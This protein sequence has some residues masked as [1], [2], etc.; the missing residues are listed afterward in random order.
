MAAQIGLPA[1]G[2]VDRNTV[3]GLVRAH[4]AAQATGVRAV[5]GCRLDL[6]EGTSLLLYPHDKAAWSRLCRLLTIGKRRAGKGACDLGW[7]D[8][9]EH[10]AGFSAVLIDDTPGEEMAMN[11]ARLRQAFGEEAHLA[12]VR[13]FLP[14]DLDRLDRAAGLARAARVQT[15]A[16]NDALY[17]IPSR[18]ILQDVVTAI[19]EGCT[20]DDLGRRRERSAGRWLKPP[21]EMARLFARWPEAVAATEKLTAKCCFS[22]SELT[23]Q[24]PDEISPEGEPAQEWLARL[25]RERLPTRYP[26]GA[27]PK[28]LEQIDHEL[29]L[30]GELRYAPYFLTVY[31]IVEAANAMGILCQGRG[32]AANSAVCFVLGITAIR[33]EE[34]GL[35]FERFVS[36][37]RGEPPDIDVD[38]DSGRREEVIQWVYN[39]YGRDHAALTATIVRYRGRGAIREVGK[40]LGL[41]EDITAALSKMT[42]AWDAKGVTDAQAKE[43]NLNL[44]DRRLRMTL[45]LARLLMGAPRHL[46]QHPGGFVLTAAPLID[47]VPIEPAAMEDR[48]VIEWDKDDIDALHF[49]KVDVLGLGM[50]GAMS[51]FFDMLREYKGESYDLA[52]VPP[53]EEDVYDMICAADTVGVFQIE[54]RAQMAMLPRMRPRN[55]DDLTVEV[56]VVRPGPIQGEM[57]HPYLKRRQGLEVPHYPTPEFREV[58]EK[59]LGVPLFQEQA[60]SIAIKCGGFTPGE[61]D[62]LRR[63]MAT[64]K[65]TG[66]VS[67]FRDKL[68]AGMVDHGLSREFAAR[69]FKQLEGFGS[70]GFPMSHAASFAKIAYIS[71][72]AKCRHPDLFLA[73]LLNA[74]PMGFYAPAQLVW[75][76]R[77]HGVEVRPVDVNHSRWDCTIEE[78]SREKGW[79]AIRLGLRMVSGFGEVDAARL[80]GARMEMPFADPEELQLRAGLTGRAVAQLVDADAFG[81]CTMDRRAAGWHAAKLRD[82][83][84]PL[85]AEEWAAPR[86]RHEAG[87]GF[88]PAPMTQGREVVEDYLTT[89]LSL[90]AH[91]VSFIRPALHRK[92]CRRAADVLTLKDRIHLRVAGLV[93]A[94]QRP[95][96]A[97]GVMFMTLEDETGPMNIIVWP[98]L[99]QKYRRIV[100]TASMIG[101]EGQLQ[102]E[103]DVRHIITHRLVDLSGALARVGEQGPVEWRTGRGDEARHGGGPDA[104][105]IVPARGGA[106][107]TR[108]VGR[109]GEADNVRS[110][111]SP[112]LA[113]QV[114]EHPLKLRPRNFR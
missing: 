7:E 106:Q 8:V 60:M 4:Q 57:V 71:S 88:A 69:T 61:A 79:R 56:A 84:L 66:G 41:P 85:F 92:G 48:Q 13:R 54:S 18:R 38:F 87:D 43:L 44:E 94:R 28:V 50:L 82:H 110:V 80:V 65:S 95:G 101:V 102:R 108:A 25:V 20:V 98:N 45:D 111:P 19:R 74:Q 70:Y 62:E 42:W 104:R 24:Y 27:P 75:C 103:G 2:I 96:S 59:T 51:R 52:A 112:P 99:F 83:A 35:L 37:E 5:L 26:D 10:R 16:T 86:D 76:A 89:G 107:L 81:S 22:L 34:G 40:A 23:Y 91:P 93:L 63:A 97:K 6:R 46:S 31:R 77:N 33:P 3:A 30:I 67:H 29:S 9:A 11:L 21:A 78:P 58:L 39:E 36:R 15:L 55:L 68:I 72:W 17:H 73:A 100:L 1:L 109:P 53:E 14:D 47:L 64:F 105:G 32:S 114:A 49:M 12:L 113:G 90:K